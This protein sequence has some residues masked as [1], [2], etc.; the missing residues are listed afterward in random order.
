MKRLCEAGGVGRADLIRRLNSDG[1]AD[2][3]K[4]IGHLIHEGLAEEST[5]GRLIPIEPKWLD[6]LLADTPLC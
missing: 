1:L 4:M 2:P 6:A 3:T 5:S